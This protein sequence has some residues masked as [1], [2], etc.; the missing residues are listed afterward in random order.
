M[1]MLFDDSEPGV[2]LFCAAAQRAAA[3]NKEDSKSSR[4]LMVP[5]WEGEHGRPEQQFGGAWRYSMPGFYL[6]NLRPAQEMGNWHL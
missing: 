4:I 1:K 6:S 2:S 3:K 5:R